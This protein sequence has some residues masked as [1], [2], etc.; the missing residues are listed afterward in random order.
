M[1]DNTPYR[2][3]PV[4]ILDAIH[5]YATSRR[6]PG[7]FV[8]AV[9]RNDLREVFR[10]ADQP[11]LRGLGD[12]LRYLHQEVPSSCWGSAA[13]VEAWLNNAPGHAQMDAELDLIEAERA[14]P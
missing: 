8:L 6:R 5:S 2:L 12:V 10:A 4:H 1:D 3:A 13:T 14:T 11:S 7:G 9:L